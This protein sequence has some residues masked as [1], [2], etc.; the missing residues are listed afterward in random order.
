LKKY[1]YILS[2]LLLCSCNY[3]ESKKIYVTDDLV[4][5]KLRNLDKS[6]VDKYP[7]FAN[8]ETENSNSDIEKECFIATLSQHISTSFS[9][10]KLVLNNELDVN[11]QVTIEITNLGT[12]NI[13]KLVI[14][15]ELKENI[16]NIEELVA[17][18]ILDLPE[19][20]PAYKKTQSGELIAV[21]T[22]FT[23]PV[24]VVAEV[25]T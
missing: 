17:Q 1:S 13:I 25:G 5:E 4:E 16:P 22:L 19:V 24:H 21:N 18:S 10:H 20:K 11:F 7:V 2:L 3:F 23:I 9:E 15:S 12:I 8:C 6:S 14:N